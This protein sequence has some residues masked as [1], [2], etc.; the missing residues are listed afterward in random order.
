MSSRMLG[1]SNTFLIF[2]KQKQVARIFR[3]IQRWGQVWSLRL[4]S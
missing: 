2:L 4:K 1:D 3:D